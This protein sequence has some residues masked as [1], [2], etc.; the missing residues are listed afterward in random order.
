[1]NINIRLCKELSIYI[2]TKLLK[3]IIESYIIK[4]KFI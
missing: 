4:K 2:N 1:M 3:L